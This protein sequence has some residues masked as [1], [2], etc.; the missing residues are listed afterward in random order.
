MINL[1]LIVF[2]MA[3]NV[4]LSS[5]AQEDCSGR[6]MRSVPSQDTIEGANTQNGLT[7]TLSEQLLITNH[8][9]ARQAL[10][11][12]LEQYEQLTFLGYTKAEIRKIADNIGWK[13]SLENTSS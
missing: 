5:E 4:A 6:I 9:N 11:T 3:G 10:D 13:Q 12:I 7:A 1:F 2:L 8:S